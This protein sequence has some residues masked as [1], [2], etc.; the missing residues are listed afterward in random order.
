MVLAEQI[1]TVCK[2]SKPRA[3]FYVSRARINGLQN[4]CIACSARWAKE[5]RAGKRRARNAYYYRNRELEIAKVREWQARNA[6]KR[7]EN[8]AAHWKR[9]GGAIQKKKQLER[10]RAVPRWA[11]HEKISTLYKEA[12]RLR[13]ESGLE[14]HVDHIVPIKSPLVCGLHWEGNLQILPG[15]D[16]IR[17][18]NR[19][20]PDMPNPQG[21]H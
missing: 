1:C 7:R 11:D 20:W 15:T 2:V 4:Y 18:G 17:K 21:A 16:N 8:N 10:L 6:D 5:H 12:K 19:H 9:M 13:D 14:Y 3:M